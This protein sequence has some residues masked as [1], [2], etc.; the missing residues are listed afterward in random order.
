MRKYIYLLI[1]IFTFSYAQAQQDASLSMYMFNL[2]HFNPAYAGSRECLQA[3]AIYRHQWVN[4]EGAPRTVS[5]TISSPIKGKEQYNWGI[6]LKGDQLGLTKYAY[7]DAIFSY[8]AK[9]NDNLNLNIGVSPGLMFYQFNIKD[10]T[11]LDPDKL[12]QN[13]PNKLM[14]NVGLGLFLHNKTFFVG[15]AIPHLI[16]NSFKEDKFVDYDSAGQFNH[17]FAEGGLILGKT[18]MVKHRPSFLVKYATNAPVQF[19]LNYSVLLNERF[20]L[21]LSGRFGGDIYDNNGKSKFS[22]QSVVP[23]LRFLI[24]QKFEIGY[25]YDWSFT[26]LG[27]S[28][29]GTHEFMLGYNLC[30]GGKTTR[31]VN[32]RYVNYY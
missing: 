14:P 9:L 16:L 22:V 8:K 4:I 13:N 5:L 17:F 29:S 23:M 31:F 2:L 15:A 3:N 28:Q 1:A 20:W 27:K 21:G 25:A 10:A 6:S 12:S 7:L 11:L 26:Q 30:G 18:D 32:P 19:D 24:N